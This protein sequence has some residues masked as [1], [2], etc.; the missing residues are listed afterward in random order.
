MNRSAAF[1]RGFTQSM[2]ASA[3]ASRIRASAFSC[4][5]R[6]STLAILAF[7][8]NAS[9]A[10][11]QT[12]TPAATQA[13]AP[14]AMQAVSPAGCGGTVGDA[15][16]LQLDGTVPIVAGRGGA[17]ARFGSVLAP[18]GALSVPHAAPRVWCSGV[19][20]I[21]GIAAASDHTLFVAGATAVHAFVNG[22]EIEARAFAPALAPGES[23]VAV[24]L[25][26]NGEPE[27]AIAMGPAGTTR[28]A[29]YS[30][31]ANGD[32]PAPL[33]E[34]RYAG[35]LGAVSAIA[36]DSQGR[37]YAY[38][39][40]GEI[41]VFP[42][43]SSGAATPARRLYG[44]AT[45]LRPAARGPLHGSRQMALDLLGQLYAADDGSIAR[46]A[47]YSDDPNTV[48]S[49]VIAIDPAAEL[50]L[51]RGLATDGTNEYAL[52]VDPATRA[53]TLVIFSPYSGAGGGAPTARIAVP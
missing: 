36:I 52:S 40:G 35:F 16:A 33:R 19:T 46:F 21:V 25:L 12:A 22:R 17:I 1:A 18:S 30:A 51:V 10:A 49:D 15:V 34:F 11:A 9:Q 42:A 26:P 27:L 38:D 37:T 24:A 29:V 28:F 53:A 3:R 44:S 6:V 45:P 13:A 5:A 4:G 2:C 48:T 31:A 23:I 14:A 39:D 50:G 47:F 20:G 32:R 7:S 8:M 41:V 43:E